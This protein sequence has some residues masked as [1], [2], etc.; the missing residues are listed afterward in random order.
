MLPT[1]AAGVSTKHPTRKKFELI[2]KLAGNDE[3]YFQSRPVNFH[4]RKG[5]FNVPSLPHVAFQTRR[6]PRRR[7]TSGPALVDFVALIIGSMQ[8]QSVG[9]SILGDLGR[10]H[11]L[12]S[13]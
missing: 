9:F 1:P 2:Q 6:V 3:K 11:L 8:E 12:W 5:P 7:W 13:S 10:V 4:S